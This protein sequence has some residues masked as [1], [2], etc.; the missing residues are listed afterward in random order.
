MV[1]ELGSYAEGFGDPMIQTNTPK[2]MEE[3]AAKVMKVN[4]A[5]ELF[6]TMV[7]VSLNIEN[8]TLEVN[9][10][11]NILVMGEK[12]K[13]MLQEELDNEIKFQKGY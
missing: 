1:Q 8:L 6:Q 3:V 9:I 7:I 10:L 4:K 11:H 5:P 12:E 2:S 13:V